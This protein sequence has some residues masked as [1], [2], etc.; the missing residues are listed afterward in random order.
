M[1][2]LRHRAFTLIE[3]LVVIAVIGAMIGSLGLVLRDGD[4][5]SALQAGQ[6][7][8]S[9][10]V[11]AARAQAALSRQNVS[12]VIWADHAGDPATYLRRA[13]VMVETA[14]GTLVQRGDAID[15]PQG[16]YFVPPDAG[17]AYP[18]RLETPADWTIPPHDFTAATGNA[19]AVK[20]VELASG[21]PDPTVIA[22]RFYM[23]ASLTPTG[24]LAG[25]AINTLVIATGDPEPDG[26][27]IRGINFRNSDS[28]RGLV[29]STYGLVTLVNEKS[30]FR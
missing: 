13:A 29:V 9:A 23:A 26:G 5:S 24:V 6:S 2:T 15:L 11:S 14:P 25:A 28:M 7:S 20:N 4:R 3:L 27:G 17:G 1:H 12:I 21:A 16:I 30:G 19:S 10:L 18:A 8:L 22:D